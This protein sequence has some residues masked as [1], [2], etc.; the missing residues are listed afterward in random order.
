MHGKIC[1]VKEK[2]RLW[3]AVAFFA[4][5]TVGYPGSNMDY[6]Y[7]IAQLFLTV[8]S[9]K[10]L[11]EI[12]DVTNLAKTKSSVRGQQQKKIVVVKSYTKKDGTK[13]PEHRRST[14]N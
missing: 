4:G 11:T 13:V 1:A 10:R 9:T 12:G 7:K 5:D 2:Q 8:K 3:Q 6:R 14:P